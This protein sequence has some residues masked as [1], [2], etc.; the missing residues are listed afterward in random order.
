VAETSL[1]IAGTRLVIDSGLAKEA[2]F[3]PDRRLTVLELVHI[4]RSS[5]DQRKVRLHAARG[6]ARAGPVHQLVKQEDLVQWVL[7]K[8]D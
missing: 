4:S 5:A 6:S 1:T 3:D 2:R 8:A 7:T